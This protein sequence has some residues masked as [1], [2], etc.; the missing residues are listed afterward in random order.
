MATVVIAI[1]LGT[2]SGGFAYEE[3]LAL[4]HTA[5][6]G[7]RYGATLPGADTGGSGTTSWLDQVAQQAQAAYAGSTVPANLTIC[8]AYLTLSGGSVQGQYRTQ[9]G[10]GSPSYGSG[11]CGTSPGNLPDPRVLVVATQPA[12]FNAVLFSTSMTLSSQGIAR[13]EAT[14]S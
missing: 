11:M 5:R 10:S 14:A 1:A 4:S 9:T 3:W 7:A 12:V 13:Y 2:L 8:V 6:E